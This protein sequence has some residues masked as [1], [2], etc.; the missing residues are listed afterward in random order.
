MPVRTLMHECAVVYEYRMPSDTGTPAPKR[1]LGLI[2][3]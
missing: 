3:E 2:R 1:R